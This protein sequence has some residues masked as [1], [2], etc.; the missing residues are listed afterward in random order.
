MIK[1][2]VQNLSF[3]YGTTPVLKN[4]ELKIKQNT[5]N[6]F[7]GLNGSG[8]TTLLKLLTSV[9]SAPKNT[10][11]I[12]GVDVTELSASEKSK[13]VSYV[14]QSISDDNDFLVRDYLT[15]GR[16]NKIKFYAAPREEDFKKALAVAN[17]LKIEHKLNLKKKT[18]FKKR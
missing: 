8:K 11:F 7:L 6:V 13:K 2:D 12:D 3:A 1:L 16:M 18:N 15:F 5:I 14:P 4:L 10:I 9:L 17:E